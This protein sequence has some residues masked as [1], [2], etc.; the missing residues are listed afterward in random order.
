MICLINSYDDLDNKEL[1]KAAKNGMSEYL[2]DKYTEPG[3]TA[4]DNCDGDITD[5]V[6]VVKNINDKNITIYRKNRIF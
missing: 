6:K 1:L 4:S 3:F 2:G 5:K